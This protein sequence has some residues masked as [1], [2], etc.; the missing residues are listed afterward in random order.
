MS[1][2]QEKS[3]TETQRFLVKMCKYEA[4]E[5]C[6]VKHCKLQVQLSA[7]RIN[8]VWL[9]YMTVL[10]NQFWIMKP[11]ENVCPR[12]KRC[13]NWS[14]GKTKTLQTN[15]FFF[16]FYGGNQISLQR[17]TMNEINFI[18]LPTLAS[19]EA[20]KANKCCRRICITWR[21]SSRYRA[22]ISQ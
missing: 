15:V 1:T 10:P 6:W 3:K 4:E 19:L 8:I 12:R 9:V 18:S 21:H 11:C 13:E 7:C 20:L 2:C 14:R 16:F 22:N 5:T 17:T